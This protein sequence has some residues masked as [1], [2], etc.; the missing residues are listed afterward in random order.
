[1]IL[2]LFWQDMMTIKSLKYIYK[3]TQTP[4]LIQPVDMFPMTGGCYYPG[5]CRQY[6]TGCE[7]CPVLKNQMYKRLVRSNWEYK[8]SVYDSIRCALYSNTYMLAFAKTNRLFENTLIGF[9]SMVLNEGVFIEQGVEQVREKMS[10]STEKK[11]IMMARSVPPE[12]LHIR[13]G[14]AFMIAAINIFCQNKTKNQIDQMLLILVGRGASDIAR[15]IP[16]QVM[17]LGIVK[18]DKLIDA[19]SISSLFLSTTVDDAG[20]TMVNQSIMCSTPV[21]CFDIGS[22]ID[23]IKHKENGYKANIK[24]VN[25]LAEGIEFIYGMGE[26]EYKKMRVHTRKIAMSY[27]STEAYANAVEQIYHQIKQQ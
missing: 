8:K 22:A 19:Y 9:K 14:I 15:E 11:F 4:I 6:N 13:K 16:I 24:D 3:K 27:N 1:M 17:D 26:K 10:I 23:V 5:D 18:Q 12:S 20:P 2:T 7:N 25:G 21:V